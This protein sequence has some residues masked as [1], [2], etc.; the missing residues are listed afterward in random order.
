MEFINL[1]ML[2]KIQQ[3]F[4]QNKG[5][6]FMLL[7]SLCFSLLS[8][9]AKH[10]NTNLPSIQLVFFRSAVGLPFLFWSLWRNPPI[11]QIGGKFFFLLYRGVVGAFTMYCLFY[12]LEHLGLSLTNTY[13]QAFPLFIALFT[14]IWLPEEGLSSKQMLYL[15]MGFFGMVV[16]FRP[17]AQVSWQ[18]HSIGIIYAAGTAL[19]YIAIKEAQ[20]YY[21][22]RWV[23]VSFMA[24]GFFASIFSLAMGSLFQ[25]KSSFWAAEWVQ[26]TGIEWIEALI[27]G[28]LALGVQGFAT[29]ALRNAPTTIVGAVAN[30]SVLFSIMIE[31]AVGRGLP[32]WIVMIGMVLVI[33]GSIQVTKK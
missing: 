1:N 26:P 33:W 27:L 19:G 28:L 31:I 10:M 11:N 29:L 16:I 6:G 14:Y 2:Q 5:I 15:L 7:S 12:A 4:N 32:D 3:K 8:A 24:C 13:G 23:I 18:K 30:S 21:D 9:L 20:K 25:V 17:D 22:S